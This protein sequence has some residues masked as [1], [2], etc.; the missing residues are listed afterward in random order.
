MAD[1]ARSFSSWQIQSLIVVLCPS[2]QDVVCAQ[3]SVSIVD[4]NIR[5]E[6]VSRTTDAVYVLLGRRNGDR[7]ERILHQPYWQYLSIIGYFSLSN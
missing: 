7:Y 6:M 5:R 3:R 4:W 2:G 1:E